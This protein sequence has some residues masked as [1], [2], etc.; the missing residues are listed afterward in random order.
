MEF[1]QKLTSNLFIVGA[2]FFF[3]AHAKADDICATEIGAGNAQALAQ[4]CIE[5]SPATH[6]PCNVRNSCALI[7]DEIARG[8]GLA[9]QDGDEIPTFCKDY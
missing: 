4:Q 5:I 9:Q 2:I 7:R 6:P 1:A 3:V 8:C